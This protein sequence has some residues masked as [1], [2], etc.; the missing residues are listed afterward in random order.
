[1]DKK[2]LHFVNCTFDE[3]CVLPQNLKNQENNFAGCKFSAK[4]FNPIVDAKE[5]E[6]LKKSLGIG[7]S[8]SPNNNFY[9]IEKPS[10]SISPSEVFKLN[11]NMLIR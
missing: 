7:D 6:N 9:E 8:K 4:I 11:Q 10:N 2:T 3:G 1:M 5:K